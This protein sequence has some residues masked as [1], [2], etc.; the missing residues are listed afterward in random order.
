MYFV[1]EVEIPNGLQHVKDVMFQNLTT[2]VTITI[3]IV[4]L[5]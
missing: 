2:T 1:S 4:L 3:N 5:V